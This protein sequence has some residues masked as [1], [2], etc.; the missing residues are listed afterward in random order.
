MDDRFELY[1]EDG[2][3]AYIDMMDNHP[4][5]IEE[6][7]EKGHFDRALVESKSNMDK[8]LKGAPGWHE[9]ARSPKATLY[10]RR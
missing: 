10:E 7:R 6:W 2:L 9:V 1:G 4:E 3:R 5:R 8:Y